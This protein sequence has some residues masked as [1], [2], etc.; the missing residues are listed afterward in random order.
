VAH[1]SGWSRLFSGAALAVTAGL[2]AAG[3]TSG[4]ASTSAGSASGTATAPALSAAQAR[5]VF[6]AYVA[7]SDQATRTGDATLALSDVTGAQWAYVSATFKANAYFHVRAPYENYVYASP[8]LYLPEAAGYPRAFVVAV[9]R[10]L[11]GSP[12]RQDMATWVAGVEEPVDGTVLMVFQQASATAPWQLA[13]TSQLAAGMSLPPMAADVSGQVQALAMSQAALLSRPD[14][15][16]PLQAAVV[17]EGP[18]SPAARVVASG[19]LTTGLYQAARG[20][21]L[22]IG[23]RVPWGDVRQW[24]L[25]GSNYTKFALRTADGGALVFYAMYLNTTVAVPGVLNDSPIRPGPRIAI[26]DPL[27]PLL[28]AGATAPHVSLEGQE[29]LSFA[30]VDPPAGGGKIRVIA[31]GGGLT[32][33]SAS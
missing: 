18:A 3:C 22:G 23:L 10:A 7:T 4:P 32:Y 19:P 13:S 28:P 11:A 9:H 20:S 5:Q 17:D 1:R 27:L 25:D 29:L 31:I 26:P 14:V 30:A 6:D 15:V 2:A 12:P 21:D 33:A 16:G 24:D 8:V